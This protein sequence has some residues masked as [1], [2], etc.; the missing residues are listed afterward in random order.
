ME[1]CSSMAWTGS[2]INLIYCK[3][4]AQHENVFL[5]FLSGAD[6]HSCFGSD[7]VLLPGSC[8]DHRQA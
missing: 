4:A 1:K 8:S 6:S 5:L 3:M 2:T 7:C